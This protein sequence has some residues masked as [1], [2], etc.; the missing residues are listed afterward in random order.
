MVAFVVPE[1]QLGTAYGFMQSIQNL[2]LALMSMAAGS[3]LDLKGYLFLEVFFIACLC[4][5]LLA[6]VLLY[7]YDY[8]KEGDLNLSAS[9]RASRIKSE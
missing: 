2:G 6:V 3:I 5:A 4:L 9:T 1:H 8:Y 7:L